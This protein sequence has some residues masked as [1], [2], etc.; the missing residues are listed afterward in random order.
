MEHL[1]RQPFLLT[2][3]IIVTEV[4]CLKIDPPHAG[5]HVRSVKRSNSERRKVYYMKDLVVLKFGM[6]VLEVPFQ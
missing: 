3:K 1:Q 4:S 2:K 5:V 6:N